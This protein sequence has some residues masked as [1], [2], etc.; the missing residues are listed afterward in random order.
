MS[1]SLGDK[2]KKIRKNDGLTQLKFCEKV[3]M[4]LGTLKG[5]ELNQSEVSSLSLIKIGS[6]PDYKKYALWLISDSTDPENGQIAPG[7]L[8]PEQTKKAAQL[9]QE[10]YEAQA[11]KVITDALMM[12][13]YLDWFTAHTDKMEFDD[14]A[15]LLLKDLQPVINQRFDTD[16]KIQAIKS[17]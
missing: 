16:Q 14:C 13:C 8:E 17:A 3:D 4:K 2:V 15:K 9:K 1:T 7:D 12:F 11:A 5:Y 6:H 10:E